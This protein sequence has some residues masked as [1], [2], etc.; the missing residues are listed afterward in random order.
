MSHLTPYERHMLANPAATILEAE[1]NWLQHISRWGSSGYPVRK[2]GRKWQ[3]DRMY[4][5]GGCPSLF[6]TKR[7]AVERVELYYDML[8]DKNA[9]R[10]VGT[11]TARRQVDAAA[12]SRGEAVT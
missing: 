11:T 3:F 7:A 8:L 9:G 6:T 12:R 4:N 2:L 5:A 10:P 1:W